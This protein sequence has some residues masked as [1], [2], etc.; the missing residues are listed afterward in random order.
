M[1]NQKAL[2][3]E[4]LLAFGEYYERTIT[5]TQLAMYVEDLSVL[6]PE[7]LTAACK[8]YRQEFKNEKFPLPAK[9]I[10]L[11]RPV[12]SSEDVGREVSSAIFAALHADG[13]SNPQRARGRMGELGW[14]IIT[15]MGGWANFCAEVTNENQ[16]TYRAQVR[17]LA[18]TMHRRRDSEAKRSELALPNFETVSKISN[19]TKTIGVIK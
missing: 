3:T 12:Q 5:P 10:A 13:H 7:E 15:R 4:I 14:E 8:L 17:E 6:T 18:A 1:K 11:A 9:L 2:L 19:L 16:T